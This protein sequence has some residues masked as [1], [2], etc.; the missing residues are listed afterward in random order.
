MQ[1]SQVPISAS[2]HCTQLPV[3]IAIP[4]IRVKAPSTEAALR[5]NDCYFVNTVLLHPLDCAAVAAHG[6]H[7]LDVCQ[8][9]RLD[10]V[11]PSVTLYAMCCLACV[12]GVWVGT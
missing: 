8:A 9:E 6:T 11:K 10:I 3:G 2:A 7:S 4:S 1:L 5:R 12:R